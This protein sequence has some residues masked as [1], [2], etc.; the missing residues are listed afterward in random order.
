M[1]DTNRA[2][3]GLLA[4]ARRSE[5]FRSRHL[6]QLDGRKPDTARPGMNQHAIPR[7]Q[8]GQFVGQYGC[9]EHRGDRGECRRRHVRRRAGDQFLSRH[10]FRPERAEREAGHALAWCHG[11]DVRTGFDNPATEFFTEQALLDQAHGPEH[12]QEIEPAGLDRDAHFIGFQGMPRQRLYPQGLDRPFIVR[13][14]HPVHLFRQDKT[15]RARVRPNQPGHL[16]VS[17]AICNV[18]LGIREQ[19]LVP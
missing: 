14:Q 6:G 1:L 12:V 15:R 13:C 3:V 10:H 7:L 11:G 16:A 18:T 5:Y 4:R 2:E 17:P 8:P 9:H 19:Q